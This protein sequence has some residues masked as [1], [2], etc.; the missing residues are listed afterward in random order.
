MILQNWETGMKYSENG[1]CQL[2]LGQVRLGQVRSGQ[3][4]A[5]SRQLPKGQVL[6]GYG[7]WGS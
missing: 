7:V 1:R 4:E 6:V 3:T 2:R 5:T